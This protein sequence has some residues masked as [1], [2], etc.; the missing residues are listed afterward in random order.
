MNKRQLL[1][2]LPALCHGLLTTADAG[3]AT[4][5]SRA[6]NTVRVIEVDE[7][8]LTLTHH[9][10]RLHGELTAPTRGWL[11]AGF[12]LAAQLRDTRFMIAATC[13]AYQRFEEH[14]AVVPQHHS[15]VSLGLTPNLADTSGDCDK[16]TSTARFSFPDQFPDGPPLCLAP[17]TRVQVM[18]AWSHEPDFDHH[19][20]WRRHVEVEL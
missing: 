8:T 16:R 5:S 1:G 6:R 4:D 20:A 18:L 10:A 2:V 19:S 3:G 15:V 9:G 17:G 7:V 12:N 11:A 14:I 13:V